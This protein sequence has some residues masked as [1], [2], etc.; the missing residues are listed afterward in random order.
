MIVLSHS[1]DELFVDGSF[2]EHQNSILGCCFRPVNLS[3]TT[4]AALSNAPLM[5]WIAPFAAD[6]I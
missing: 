5:P 3:I 1:G 4:D 6:A 2:V